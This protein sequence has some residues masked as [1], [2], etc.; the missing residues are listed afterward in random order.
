[1]KQCKAI[2]CENK[3]RAKGWCSNH[4][5]YARKYGEGKALEHKKGYR[6][7]K[8]CGCK[9]I[10]CA[11]PYHAKG[12]CHKHYNVFIINKVPLHRYRPQIAVPFRDGRSK[13]PLIHI[14]YG[15]IDRC[16]NIYN[17]SYKDYGGRGVTVCESWR[18]DFWQFVK[19]MGERPEGDTIDR[20]NNNGNYEPSNCRWADWETQANNRRK[21][22]RFTAER[23]AAKTGYSSGQIRCL[24]GG[25]KRY[26]G[27]S[28]LLEPFIKRK[29][30]NGRNFITY[31]PE[32]IPFLIER[33]KKYKEFQTSWEIRV[34]KNMGVYTLQNNNVITI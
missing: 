19:D 25:V 34:P 26:N 11:K 20:I 12:Y 17:E 16:Y 18:N 14:W 6:E 27:K 32:V 22:N 9:F 23:L 21:S 1:M 4:Y 3:S 2:G 10:G 29:I 5:L 15:M 8:Y 28:C 30:I 24:S 33:K 31:S 7:K 13:H